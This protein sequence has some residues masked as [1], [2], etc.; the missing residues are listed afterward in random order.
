MTVVSS[1]LGFMT[2]S[3][4]AR[5]TGLGMN[6]IVPRGILSK[7]FKFKIKVLLFYLGRYLSRVIIVMVCKPYIGIGLVVVFLSWQLA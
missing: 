3:A 4:M 6:S 7:G 2:S 1:H 5:F